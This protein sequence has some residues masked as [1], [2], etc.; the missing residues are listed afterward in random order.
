MNATEGNVYWRNARVVAPFAVL[1]LSCYFLLNHFPLFPPAHLPLSVVDEWV[2]FWPWT[3]WPYLLMLAIGPV[4]PLMVRSDL[5]FRRLLLAYLL[6]LPAIFVFFIFW[7]TE[8]VRPPA[9]ADESL[10]SLAY[11]VMIAVDTEGCCFPSGHIVVPVLF[12]WGLWLDGRRLG[13]FWC[14]LVALLAPTILTTKQHYFWDLLGALAI[15]AASLAV[16]HVVIRPRGRVVSAEKSRLAQMAQ[17]ASV[18][19]DGQ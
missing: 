17:A 12:A 14:G 6:T 9:P 7:P 10:H 16:A 3:V 4:L 8:Y 5:V 2:P 1:Q 15:V 19:G 11:R 13:P 18:G